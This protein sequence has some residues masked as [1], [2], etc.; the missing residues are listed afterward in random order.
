MS[1][2]LRGN[3]ETIVQGSETGFGGSHQTLG[4]AD[5]GLS[6][7][8]RQQDW[9]DEKKK[10]KKHVTKKRFNFKFS[11]YTIIKLLISNTRD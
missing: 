2:V 3:P 8:Q 5:R 6:A 4:V 7:P 9:L 11:L 1:S 10:K